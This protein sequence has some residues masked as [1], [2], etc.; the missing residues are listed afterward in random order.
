MRDMGDQPQPRFEPRPVE[1][2]AAL[3]AFIT[4]GAPRPPQNSAEQEPVTGQVPAGV[5]GDAEHEG[6]NYHLRTR[7]RRRRP[8]PGEEGAGQPLPGELPVA[9]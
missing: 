9:E 1:D 2:P 7:R 5:E 6:A 8:G 3:P 4:G